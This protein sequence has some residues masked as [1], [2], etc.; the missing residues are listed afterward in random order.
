MAIIFF[1]VNQYVTYEPVIAKATVV[2]AIA[3]TLYLLMSILLWL[4]TRRSVRNTQRMFETS[5]RP[6]I[7]PTNLTRKDEG[8]PTTKIIF[9]LTFQNF[10]TVPASE[11]KPELLVI[12]DGNV[13]PMT[14]K[15]EEE[16]MV[17]FP[18]VQTYKVNCVVHDP[19]EIALVKSASTL[20]LLFRCSY[21]S[22]EIRN[23]T[24]KKNMFTTKGMDNITL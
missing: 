4:T 23:I 2:L 17:A 22:G 24:V 15:E 6:Y 13:L 11:C 20:A 3:N 12:T 1:Q 21:T 14:S 19:H 5:H 9:G 8:T 10:G 16:H 18:N 7:G